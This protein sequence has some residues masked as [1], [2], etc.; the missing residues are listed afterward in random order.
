MATDIAMQHN[1]AVAIVGKDGKIVWMKPTMSTLMNGGD[2]NH[3][4]KTDLPLPGSPIVGNGPG[5]KPVQVGGE[6]LSNVLVIVPA[7]GGDGE[8]KFLTVPESLIPPTATNVENILSLGIK[9]GPNSVVTPPPTLVTDAP[10]TTDTPTKTS[11]GATSSEIEDVPKLPE[12]KSSAVGGVGS[13][14][15]IEAPVSTKSQLPAV[16]T[17]AT[18]ISASSQAPLSTLEDLPSTTSLQRQATSGLSTEV[19]SST[20]SVTSEIATATS[21]TSEAAS[22][23]SV[24]PVV[25]SSISTSTQTELPTFTLPQTTEGGFSSELPKTSDRVDSEMFSESSS[26]SSSRRSTRTAAVTSTTMTPEPSDPL[27][28]ISSIL[29]KTS[30]T[31]ATVASTHTRSRSSTTKGKGKQTSSTKSQVV[32]TFSTKTITF[33][34][35][36]SDPIESQTSTS[37]PEA[38]ATDGI[39]TSF[40]TTSDVVSSTVSNSQATKV[41]PTIGTTTS[42]TLTDVTPLPTALTTVTEATSLPTASSTKTEATSIPPSASSTVSNPVSTISTTVATSGKPTTT[43][44][45]T[46]KTENPNPTAAQ[47]TI[48]TPIGGNHEETKSTVS[49]PEVVVITISSRLITLEVTPSD[50]ID[51]TTETVPPAP[52]KTTEPLTDATTVS[53][54]VPAEPTTTT[55]ISQ[56]STLSTTSGN[57]EEPR[58]PSRT[59]AADRSNPTHSSPILNPHNPIGENGGKP[60]VTEKPETPVT[61]SSKT[62]EPEPSDPFAGPTTSSTANTS[63]PNSAPTKT[64]S[65]SRKT[66]SPVVTQVTLSSKVISVEILPSDPIAAAMVVT[67]LAVALPD[68]AIKIAPLPTALPVEEATPA[69][70]VIPTLPTTIAVFKTAVV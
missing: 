19:S 50:P 5:P 20:T 66:F 27:E 52:P 58:T 13:T 48:V 37:P 32:I 4:L 33:E 23:T 7:K 3:H 18:P 47:P 54:T 56:I 65:K 64:D 35:D 40:I 41:E 15:V 67:G 8:A 30:K 49:V 68:K 44:I 31:S 53:T 17:S 45:S 61:I 70:E 9:T 60:K 55:A 46:S 42:V 43:A 59:T 29:F 62:F 28:V 2:P 38:T 11:S 69:P 25:S 1:G 16:P 36:P 14:A 24:M 57:A 51:T 21:A 22:A 6:D 34:V 26:S 63:T 12:T 10:I 39:P